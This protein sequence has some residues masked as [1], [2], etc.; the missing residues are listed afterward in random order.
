MCVYF[1]DIR[2]TFAFASARYAYFRTILSLLFYSQESIHSIVWL[3]CL[4]RAFVRCWW[5]WLTM[6]AGKGNHICWDGVQWGAGECFLVLLISLFLWVSYRN[7]NTVCIEEN[8]YEHN[9]HNCLQVCHSC[10]P[11]RRLLKRR[12]EFKGFYKG[13]ANLKKILIFRPQLGV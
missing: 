12:C 13:G 3:I 8:I 9:K 7:S 2:R 6:K 4:Y 5:V 11:V 1:M 10:R